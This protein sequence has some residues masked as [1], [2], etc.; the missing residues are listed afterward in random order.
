MSGVT[1]LPETG[2][3][4]DG[5]VASGHGRAGTAQAL[6]L[7]ETSQVEPQLIGGGTASGQ[8]DPAAATLPATVVLGHLVSLLKLAS[9]SNDIGICHEICSGA[10]RRLKGLAGALAGQLVPEQMASEGLFHLPGSPDQPP[11]RLIGFEE[12]H[13]HGLAEA[14]GA[15][16]LKR[17]GRDMRHQLLWLLRSELNLSSPAGARLLAAMIARRGAP[18]LDED[19]LGLRTPAKVIVTRLRQDLTPFGLGEAIVTYRRSRRQRNPGGYSFSP[20][21]RERLQACLSFD[22]AA[23]ED[24]PDTGNVLASEPL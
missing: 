13:P 6:P 2:G 20:L 22:L 23:L 8:G 11:R 16:L 7:G 15:V 24:A 19:D 5:A 1:R 17:A 12:V 9:Q 18:V 21:F 14:D 10:A 3:A 4:S